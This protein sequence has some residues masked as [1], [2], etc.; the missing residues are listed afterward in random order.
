MTKNQYIWDYRDPYEWM[1]RVKKST[2][3]PMII[4]VAIT[5]G[6]HGK[7][8]NPNIPETAEEQ[9][10]QVYEAYKAGASVVH[11]HARD[12]DAN[13]QM[14]KNPEDYSRI[15]RLIRDRCPDII[16]NNTTGGSPTSK[17]EQ[18]MACLFAE[19]KPD[20]ASLNPGPFM[21]YYQRPER[22]DSIPHPQPAALVN[23]T[24]PITYGEV[25]D[26]ATKMKERG[27]KP[28]VELFHPGHF[29][30]IRELIK[31][32][33]LTPPYVIQLVMGFQTS[34]FPTPWNVL[35][36]INELPP[37]SLFLIPGVGAYQVPMSMMAILMGGHV[38]VGL[39]DNY[40]YR[41]GELAKS[42]AQLVERAVRMGH[43]MNREIATV[44]QAREMLG[45]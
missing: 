45:L 10:D 36:T 2:F 22:P 21:I 20:I 31:R 16:V 25:F 41:R 39:E 13:G 12:R 8:S 9:A 15:N 38:R 30:V 14:T 7:E 19:E 23:A 1:E 18:R 17:P 4:Q 40:Y 42:N 26:F 29:W 27:I 28:E 32:G 11:V 34:S 33:L 43:E 3:P 35:N 37:D 24:V 6:F 5:G 44:A